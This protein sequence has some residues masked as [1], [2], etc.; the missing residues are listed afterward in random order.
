[1]RKF[2]LMSKSRLCWRWCMSKNIF[3]QKFSLDGA[4]IDRNGFLLNEYREDTCNLYLKK[5]EK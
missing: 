4:Y 2:P 1:M 5:E 3:D